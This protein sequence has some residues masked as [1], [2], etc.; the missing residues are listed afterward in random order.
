MHGQVKNRPEDISSKVFLFL[1]Y[2]RTLKHGDFARKF[3][4]K[5]DLIHCEKATENKKYLPLLEQSNDD[6]QRSERVDT[7]EK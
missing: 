2:C 4:N 1:E 7:K 6:K 3:G 5:I